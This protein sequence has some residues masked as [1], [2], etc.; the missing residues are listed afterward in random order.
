MSERLQKLIARAGI[1][2]RRAAERLIL[3]GRI[4]VNGRTVRELGVRAD[5]ARD[6]VRLDGRR[7]PAPPSRHVYVA[8]HKPRGYVTTLRDPE[9]RPTVRD[10]LAGIGT[11]VYPVGRLDF[12]SEGLLL[13]TDDGELAHALMHPRSG[14]PKTYLARVRGLPSQE[15]LRQLE[16]GV[17]LEGRRTLPAKARIVRGERNAWVEVTVVEGRKH[18]V[19]RML[20]RVGHAVMRLRRTAYGG[21]RLGSLPVGRS[22]ALTPGEVESLRKQAG[23]REGTDGDGGGPGAA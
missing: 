8:L 12:H 3:E 10:L 11:R 6:V 7:I 15:S 16:Q 17:L 9:G 19:R 2:S 23:R 5:L 13:L 21:V 14:V 22:R 1:A 20:E 4:T 18:Q